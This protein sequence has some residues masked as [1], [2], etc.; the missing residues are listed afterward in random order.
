MYSAELKKIVEVFQ[1]ESILPEI[2]LEGRSITRKE[3]N[4]PA[5]QLAGFYERFDNDRLQV[6]G[7]VEYSYLLSLAPEQRRESILHLFQYHIPCLIV[8]KNL[9][10]FPEMIEFGRIYSIP[11]FRTAQTTTDFAAELIFW[12][13][14]E[15]ADRVMLHGVLVDIY[16][17]GVLITG[18]SGIGKSETALELIK[19]GHRLI[20]D[21]AVEIKKI[22]DRRL[23]GT[24]PEL[25]RY[26]IEFRG[27]G[28]IN[29]K[30]LFGAGAVKQQKAIDLV[31]R[32]E[33]WDG[34]TGSYD[35][36]GL[37]EEYIEILG[38]KVLCNTIP[39]RPG[40]NVAVICESAAI[41]NRQKKMGS[42]TAREFE[43]TI[44]QENREKSNK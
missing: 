41:T 32:L 18:A 19:R 5:L 4:R 10:I 43:Y 29:V 26:L 20:A 42:N 36:L 3:V 23:V 40:R 35:R 13:R 33:V 12:L 16:G 6:I 44:W 31:I 2:S 34:K 30:E 9:E 37:N 7:R 1:L 27:I 21:D 17:E 15:L 24:C 22:A 11:I 38:N 25:I 39:I 8:C 28:I 14:G